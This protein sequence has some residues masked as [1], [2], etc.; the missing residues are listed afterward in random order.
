MWALAILLES[1]IDNQRFLPPCDTESRFSA[2]NFL[3]V[4]FPILVI[5]VAEVHIM[6]SIGAL[7][8]TCILEGLCLL[9]I[10]G[11]EKLVKLHSPFCLL[12]GLSHVCVCLNYSVWCGLFAG[13]PLLSLSVL[14]LV[15]GLIFQG[16]TKHN[17]LSL[18]LWL[19]DAW[20]ILSRLVFIFQAPSDWVDHSQFDYVA[21][22][23]LLL[24]LVVVCLMVSA[25]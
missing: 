19:Q 13:V 10:T 8:L 21:S 23:S 17:Y 7:G 6:Q 5:V 15:I 12:A 14:F 2:Y 1:R 20:L 3:F 18:V 16:E 9:G 11:F 22:A 25:C 4:A 24:V